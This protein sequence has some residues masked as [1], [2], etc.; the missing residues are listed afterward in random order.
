MSTSA[1]TRKDAFLT[2]L[3]LTY[4][5]GSFIGSIVAPIK[6]GVRTADTVF[7]DADD[8]IKLVND[9]ADVTPSN[10]INFTAGSGYSYKTTR[11]AIDSVILD[12]TIANEEAIVKSKIRETKK[13]TNI[14]RLKHEYRVAEILCSTSKVTN[15]DTL[16]GTEQFNNASY[17]N[18]F[19]TIL[20]NNAISSIRSNTGCKANTLVVPFEAA[21]Y[22][23]NDTFIKSIL[24]YQHGLDVVQQS[25]VLN[26]VGLPP[27][28]KGLRVVIADA[29]MNN[30]NEGETASKGNAWSDYV[31]VGYVPGN[32][33]EDTFGIMTM[34]YEPFSVYEERLT[35]PK[36]VKI[37]TDWDYGI[38]EADLACWYLFTDVL[39]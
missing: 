10:R 25:G 8:A 12:K 27:F 4:P 6:S 22:L 31:L 18:T 13:L 15:Y 26:M 7:T 14:L 17:G 2:N 9:V 24:Q 29:R 16:S 5:T 21:M 39:A 33:V 11:K 20:L 28:I 36:G 32:D 30:A 19:C 35:N 37:I 38:L 23:A 3:A 1:T 34:E